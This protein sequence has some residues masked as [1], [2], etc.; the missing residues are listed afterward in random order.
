M[1]VQDEVFHSYKDTEMYKRTFLSY[2][3]NMELYQNHLLAQ[4]CVNNCQVPML[5]IQT[6][7]SL[8][9]LQTTISLADTYVN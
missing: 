9:V 3:N 7:C 4:L 8:S 2:I 5:Y 6:L 1:C